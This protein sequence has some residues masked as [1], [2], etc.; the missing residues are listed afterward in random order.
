MLGRL[1]QGAQPHQHSA[2]QAPKASPNS[3]ARVWA[4]SSARTNASL[5]PS[6]SNEVMAAWVVPPLDVTCARSCA[7]DK[8]DCWAKSAAPST[9]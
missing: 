3:R 7:G 5:T 9:V 8:G 1:H 2:P 4:A 6:A